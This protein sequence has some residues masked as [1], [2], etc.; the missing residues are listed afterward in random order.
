MRA[1]PFGN[2]NESESII[3]IIGLKSSY[4]IDFYNK[5]GEIFIAD[6]GKNAIYKVKQDGG[7][8]LEPIITTGLDKPQGIAV[9]WV[10]ENLYWTDDGTNLIE[11]KI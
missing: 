4:A 6:D 8:K 2:D 10:A 9:D 5:T 1:I 11:V 3:P 7:G